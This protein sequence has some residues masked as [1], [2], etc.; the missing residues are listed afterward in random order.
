[1]ELKKLSDFKFEI[2]R[3][4]SRGMTTNVVAYTT[5]AMLEKIKTD[6]TL[7]QAVNASSL[8][9]IVGNVLLMPDAHEGYG[10]P[11]GG[12]VA[13]DSDSGIISPGAVG[14]D[15]NCLVP[16]TKVYDDN[17][18]WR[19]ISD[20]RSGE[21]VSIFDRSRGCVA[22]AKVLL[23][24]KKGNCDKVLKI[25]TKLGKEVTATKDHPILTDKGMVNAG[26]LNK[27]D[28]LAVRGFDGIEYVHPLRKPIVTSDAIAEVLDSQGIGDAGN[29]KKIVL[30]FLKKR[31]LVEMH[32]D[33][34]KLP[35][36]IKLIGFI[37]GDGTIPQ[38]LR[39]SWVTI[40]GKE[41]DLLSVKYDLQKL[42]I[43]GSI[44]HRS[45]HHKITTKYGTQEF[46]YEEYSLKISSIAFCALLIALGAPQGNK[47]A[48]AYRVPEWIVNSEDWQKRLFLSAYFGAE[49]TKPLTN[50]G[51]NFG[52]PAFSVSKLESLQDNAVAFLLDIKAMLASL[53]IE[54]SNPMIV[55]GYR[56]KGIR[57]NTVG[58]R[59]AI[60]SNTDNLIRFFGTVGYSYNKEK[61]RLSSLAT[62]YL[63]LVKNIREERDT[64]RQNAIAM[65]VQG[66]SPKEII[67]D[68][69]CKTA[70]KS[71]IR[72]SIWQ[73]RGNAR[74]WTEQ[75]FDAFIEKFEIGKSG[76]IYDEVE[77]IVEEDYN[78]DVFDITVDNANHNFI[79]NGIVVSNCGI[80]LIKTNLTEKEIRPQLNRL[81]DAMFK[82][83]PSGVGSR[84]KTGFS[85]EDLERTSLE[86]VGYALE[87]GYGIPGTWAAWRKTAQ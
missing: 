23:A 15:I 51:Y 43:R 53:G 22:E 19:A 48:K 38:N 16:G 21:T 73:S 35:I 14:Y 46:D 17:G 9:G 57:G 42:D 79:A 32:S 83:V 40:Y 67:A 26:L 64:I 68:L 74:V 31:G 20:F 34:G 60:E 3:D 10:F 49:M 75:R 65:Y 41:D 37:L 27:G 33:D 4:E 59:L 45:R 72:H 50:N 84:L 80:R 81:L 85:Q 63:T 2:E 66:T 56:Y 12:V 7:Q 52:C 30:N 1:M 70:G 29:A 71:F 82:N 44:S 55:E 8:P 54:T 76:F 25:K 24:M 47:S 77:S 58:T 78:G 18:S 86:G 36:L 6:R 11:V 61:E 87:K 13:F 28:I 62:L 39:K 5:D 69:E